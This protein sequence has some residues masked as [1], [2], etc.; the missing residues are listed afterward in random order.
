MIREFYRRNKGLFI[1]A[2]Y[3]IIA[4]TGA[5]QLVYHDLVRELADA[6]RRLG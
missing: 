3:N 6:V 2:D 4:K 5:A 1:S